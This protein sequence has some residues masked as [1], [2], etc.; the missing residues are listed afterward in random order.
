[1]DP[2]VEFDTHRGVLFGIAYRM[3][4]SVQEAEDVVQ[5][6][7]LRWREADPA[8]VENPRA[9]LTTVVTRLSIDV[10]RSARKRREEYVGEWLPEPFVDD[11]AHPADGLEFAESLSTAFL[12]MLERLNPTERAAFLLREVFDYPYEHIA[13]MLD[14]SEANCRQIVKRAKN[15][16]QTSRQRFA[17]PREE[18]ERLVLGFISAVNSGDPSAIASLLTTD[19]TFHAD[20]GGKAA[21]NKRTIVGADKIGRFMV[22][23]QTR[24]TPENLQVRL[25]T[26][27][28][29]LG[30]ILYEADRPY[31]AFSLE[32][33]DGRITAIYSMRNPDKLAHLPGPDAIPSVPN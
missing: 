17:A 14:K 32:T 16:I 12:L 18:H 22:G 19:A 24:F 7:Y 11:A 15:H 2:G 10:L 8:R 33:K 3:L 9:Y 27:N 28:G 13:E 23:V 6:A 25:A 30:V 29:R 26:V 1:M 4:G 21:A 20:H 5:D 31:A